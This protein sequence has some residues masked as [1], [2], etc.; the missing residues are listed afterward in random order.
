MY[1]NWVFP[2][3]EAAFGWYPARDQHGPHIW[4]TDHKLSITALN[5]FTRML[6]NT[7]W[8]TLS[9]INSLQISRVSH[10]QVPNMTELLYQ[11]IN[12]VIIMS[13][14]L[15]TQRTITFTPA[16]ADLTQLIKGLIQSAVMLDEK[17]KYIEWRLS[18][19]L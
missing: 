9:C 19:G 5:P 3:S 18:G 16:P 4:A 12:K 7:F 17:T 13:L 8:M 1:V 2:G 15:D 11:A 6:R 14:R 10:F